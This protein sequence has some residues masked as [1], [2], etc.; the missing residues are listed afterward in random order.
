MNG[1]LPELNISKRSRAESISET[2]KE[3]IF[4]G[5]WMPGA[6]IDDQDLAGKL[7]VSRLS[8]REALGKLVE[9]GIVERRHWKGYQVRSL[10]LH[11]VE[12]ILEVREALELVA[13]RKVVRARDPELLRE[14]EGALA[15]AEQRKSEGRVVEFRRADFRFHEI[16]YRAS[17]N[18]WIADILGNL[19]ILIELL[20]FI[21]QSED[22]A[23]VAAASIR[24][25]RRI[26]AKLSGSAPREAIS[27]M[28][29]HLR[30]HRERVRV[31]FSASD[32]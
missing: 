17:D 15:E 32:R 21:S 8:V 3:A 29:E 16:L 11:E 10:S 6:R 19:R 4:A 1:K 22:F 26:L 5:Y 12:S 18:P 7:E 13:M 27:E 30:S 2:V 28:R 24:E 14:L 23:S 9:A 31:R 25:H 20:R